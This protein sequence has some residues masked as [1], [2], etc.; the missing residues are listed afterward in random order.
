V[1]DIDHLPCIYSS[2]FGPDWTYLSL[3]LAM[4]LIAFRSEIDKKE[5]N[6]PFIVV[7]IDDK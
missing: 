3:I 7:I 2:F 6:P 1:V 5:K 4:S